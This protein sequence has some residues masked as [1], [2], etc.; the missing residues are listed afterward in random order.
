[1]QLTLTIKTVPKM[2]GTQICTVK[3]TMRNNPMI[4]FDMKRAKK[5]QVIWKM[6]EAK[7]IKKFILKSSSNLNMN[8]Q[9][10]FMLESILKAIKNKV[11]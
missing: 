4:H 6:S 9:I 1:M 2:Q 3:T 11:P 5:Q 10:Y 8:L 7:T